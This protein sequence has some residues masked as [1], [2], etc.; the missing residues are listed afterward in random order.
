MADATRVDAG[1]QFCYLTTTG[2]VSGRPHRIEIWFA[3]D[4]TTVYLLS[5]GGH[6][7]DWVRNLSRTP[8]VTVEIAGRTFEGRARVVVNHEEQH[9]AGRLLYEKYQP[10]YSGNLERWRDAA[11]PVAV[12]LAG[13]P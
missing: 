10:G 6:R 3:L 13:A 8:A 4:G 5:G 12:E 2:R 1:E 9:R 11:L 7:A